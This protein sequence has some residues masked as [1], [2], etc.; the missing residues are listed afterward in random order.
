E[1]MLSHRYDKGFPARSNVEY[2]F[3]II[4]SEGGSSERMALFDAGTS[5]WP[6]DKIL[7]Y[8]TSRRPM[9]ET[10]NLCFFPDTDYQLNWSKF[11]KDSEDLIYK[12]YHQNNLIKDYKERWTF[13]Y[14]RHEADGFQI[15]IDFFNPD[16]Y[17]DFMKDSIIHG[18]DAFALLHQNEY[19]D[20]AYLY[21]NINFLAQNVFTSESYNWGT[22]IHETAHAV[23]NLSDE[24]DGCACF[25]STGGANVFTTKS[26]CQDFNAS[27]GYPIDDC[28]LLEGYDGKTWYMSEKDVYFGAKVACEAFNRSKGYTETNCIQFIKLDGSTWYRA[29]EGVC[30]MQDDGDR[31]IRPFQRTCGGLIQGFYDS[32]PT[33]E[34]RTAMTVRE[35][36]DNMF[37]YEPLA[38]LEFSI[39][40]QK[41]DLD[42]DRIC[43]GIPE[44]VLNMKNDM[45]LR[46]PDQAS[47]RYSELN[48]NRPDC[49]HLHGYKGKDGL[50]SAGKGSMMIRVPYKEEMAKVECQLTNTEGLG[51]KGYSKQQYDFEAA[52]KDKGREMSNH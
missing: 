33:G 4:N 6:Q 50:V 17:P 15:A 21:G 41:W 44:K 27:R 38:I 40:K 46:F 11:L 43:Y 52:F 39:N 24:Y 23:F 16:N 29:E 31:Q 49:I 19:S 48:I 1:L 12:G 30:I 5:P 3:R 28:T 35:D 20:G 9:Q 7:L 51:I 34:E 2:L 25:E 36:H 18:I 8:S 37:G 13:Y 10:I 22:A 32:M 42:V 47:G 26:S 14:T 45:H